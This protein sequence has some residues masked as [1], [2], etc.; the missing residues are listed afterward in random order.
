MLNF[1][2]KPIY[3]LVIILL[4][5]GQVLAQNELSNLRQKNI[6]IQF[7]SQKIDSLTIVPSSFSLTNSETNQT[8]S[9]D[10]YHISNN[11]LIWDSLAIQK[12][13]PLTTFLKTNLKAVYRVFPYQFASPQQH[14][15]TLKLAKSPSGETYIGYD[16]SPEENRNTSIFDN[17]NLTYGGSFSRGV[18]FGNRQNLVLNSG[19]N[20]QMAGRLS[21][22][23]EIVAALSDNNIPLQPEGNTQQLQDFDKVFIQ[24]KKDSS[25]LTAGDYEI[26]NVDNYFLRYYKKLQ[27]ATFQNNKTFQKKG[28]LHTDVSA[29]IARGKFA[30]NFLVVQ[31]GNQGPYRLNGN[32]GE[33]FIII[34]SGTERVYWDGKLLER[35][36][37]NDYVIDY[38]RGDIRFTNKRMI[39]KDSRIIV[40]FEYSD[41]NYLRSLYAVNT[42]FQ[43]EKLRLYFSLFSQQDSKNTSGLSEL[44]TE[45]RQLLSTAGDGLDGVFASG[46]RPLD[47]TGNPITYRLMDTIVGGIVYD[48]I[49]MFDVSENT[50]RFTARFTEVGLG[51]GNY[52][53]LPATTNGTVYEWVAPDEFGNPQGDH[54]PIV[55]LIAPV[56]QQ[57]YVVGADYQLTSFSSLKTN[58]ALSHFD[59]NRFSDLD[60]ADD[61]GIAFYTHYELEKPFGKKDTSWLYGTTLDYEFK[62]QD[63]KALNPYRPQ[64][65][66][67]DWNVDNTVFANEQLIKGGAFLRKRQ[68][69]HL[70]YHFNAFLR[71]S[72][73]TG[74]KQIAQLSLQKKSFSILANANLLETQTDLEST[75]FFRP[76]VNISQSFKHFK[77]G[78]FIERERN[79]RRDLNDSLRL[80]SFFFD[81]YNLYL[82]S[83]DNANLTWRI[84][85]QQRVD[86]APKDNEFKLATKA[87]LV[88]LS[89]QWKQPSNSQL[90]WNFSYRELAIEDESLTEERPLSTYLGKLNYNFSLKKGFLRST[91]AYEL[92]SGQEP[93]LEYTYLQVNPGEGIYQWND[94]NQ[95]SIQQINEFEIAINQDEARFVRLSLLT[96]DFIRVN[97]VTFNQSLL[98]TPKAIWFKAEEK[99][100][101]L[102]SRFSTQSLFKINRRAREAAVVQ[103]WNP[104]QQLLADTILVGV[105]SSMRNTLFFNR[106]NA[107][108]DAQIGFFANQNKVILTTGFEDRQNQENYLKFRW[109]IL[110]AL[111]F[112]T[113]VANGEKSADSELFNE[114]DFDLRFQRIQPSLNYIPSQNWRIQVDYRFKNQENS[115]GETATNHALNSSI[116][117]KRTSQSN[118]QLDFS[119]VRVQFNGTPNTPVA[120]AMLENLQN[121]Q[122]YLWNFTWNQQLSERIQLS[123]S[124]EGRKTGLIPVVHIGRA[125]MRAL[126]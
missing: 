61:V 123:L 55:Q 125:Q 63:F 66:V 119:Y 28:R 58:V 8:I 18:S 24:I 101:Q 68:L 33:R 41:Q 42:D 78:S 99:W 126:F 106:T 71:G 54:A 109:Q 84:N 43:T 12:E 40:E 3:L 62:S 72:D 115:G 74:T 110:S 22:D 15:D 30:R 105:N 73:Y 10:W 13:M 67:R 103:A 107:K 21:N 60:A 7:P 44:S 98:L 77:I 49:L 51:N 38:N 116:N 75:Q 16:F 25:S 90:T 121:G 1:I 57:V 35:G 52:I 80:N 26:Q 97:S 46:I 6:T 19:F 82:E 27:G 20:L 50:T 14:L 32:E 89:G 59:Q 76:N 100:K 47:D 113:E 23:I 93:K 81:S 39:T 114:R 31:E 87:N 118:F 48:S 111:T 53:R 4:I 37:E 11:E 92:G 34:L 70:S 117:Y 56:S 120:F 85:G 102:L 64:E 45:D 86:Y 112:S 9:S 17:Q 83:V 91:T 65:F 96:N 79:E 124:Y 2:Q 122:N 36:L 104:F 88:E 5:S 108:F 69:G 94:Y 29:A 95:D